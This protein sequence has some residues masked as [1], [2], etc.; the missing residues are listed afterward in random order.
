MSDAPAPAPIV[1][2]RGVSMQFGAQPV[3][4]DIDLDIF[5]QD[6][7]CVIGESGCGKTV[8][9]KLIVGLL[10]PTKGEVLFEN[11]PIH[12]LSERNLT[13]LRLRVGFLFQQAAL[14][15]SLNVF[16]NV[17]FGL[18]AKGGVSDADIAAKVRERI[19]EVG[20]PASVEA[21]MPAELS[22]GMRK[23]V[24]LARALALDPDMM[25][26]DEPTTGLDPIMTDVINELILQTR[27]RRPVTSVIVTHELR[28]VHKCASRVVML[29]PRSRLKPDD[30]QILYDGPPTGLAHADDARVRQFVEGEARDRLTEL[31]DAP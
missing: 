1:Q 2:L 28:T 18:R 12:L 8:L 29:Y 23:R 4:A 16:D 30:K 13:L 25:L 19:L 5:P 9:L 6:T 3:L 7:L 22:G 24:G 21:K 20:L 10:K 14:F 27:A 26:Y 11:T 17:A 15:D 31:R